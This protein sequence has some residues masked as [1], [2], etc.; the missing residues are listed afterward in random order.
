MKR[1]LLV[2]VVVAVAATAAACGSG[3]DRPGS[4]SSASASGTSAEATTKAQFDE[5]DAT[6]TLRV[7]LQDYAFVG[8]PPTAKGPNVLFVATVA[9]S[10]EHELRVS[11]KDGKF[12]GEIPPFASGPTKKLALELAPGTYVVNCLVTEGKKTHEQL[13]MRADLVVE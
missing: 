12:L 1:S 11:T 6:S 9:G 13:G 5:K 2:A 3:E 10:N 4:S 7:T 8:L